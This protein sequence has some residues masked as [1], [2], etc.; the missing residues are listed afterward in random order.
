MPAVPPNKHQKTSKNGWTRKQRSSPQAS[1]PSPSTSA[2]ANRRL[3]EARRQSMAAATIA[4]NG[5]KVPPTAHEL[6]A[7]QMSAEAARM[8]AVMPPTDHAEYLRARQAQAQAHAAAVAVAAQPR[9]APPPAPPVDRSRNPSG[10]QRRQDNSWNFPIPKK[11]EENPF[12]EK[13]YEV[14]IVRYMVTKDVSSPCFSTC[15]DALLMSRMNAWPMPSQW[16]LNP[17]SSG[18]CVPSYSISSSKYMPN[19][20]YVPKSSTSL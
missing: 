14:D 16:M 18:S 17:R 9:P 19:S 7:R 15:R 12:Q 5:F 2:S 20:D 3:A 13:D 1:G 4:A 11:V 10:P 8:H 6:A